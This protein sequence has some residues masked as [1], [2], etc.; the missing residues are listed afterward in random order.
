MALL[1]SWVTACGNAANE[2]SGSG[3]TGGSLG[4]AGTGGTSGQGGSVSGASGSTAAGGGA[5]AAAGAA[6]LAG[7]AGSSGAAGTSGC[8]QSPCPPEPC[9]LDGSCTCRNDADC[10]DANACNGLE[11]C[12]ADTGFCA[13]G[14]GV[15]CEASDDLCLTVACNPETGACDVS[16]AA[17]DTPCSDGNACTTND[18]C[19]EGVCEGRG[20]VV[21]SAVDACHLPGT[22]DPETGSCTNPEQPDGTTC[23]DGDACTNGDACDDGVC[24][25]SEPVV[26]TP[27]SA[28]HLA[29][30]CDP[31]SGECSNPLAP[32]GTECDDGLVC[33]TSDT[34]TAGNCGGAAMVCNDGIACTVDACL[35]TAGGC[36]ANGSACA[37]A[38]DA[39]CDDGNA[40]NGTER[41][42]LTTLQCL[43]GTAKDCRSFDTACG[44]GSCNPSTGECFSQPKRN[45]TTCSDDNAC[46]RS[47]SCQNGTC[48][49][50][51]PVVCTASDQCHAAG[52]CNP[53]TGTCSN[54]AK[55]NGA[56]CNDGNACTRSDSCQDGA[57]AGANPIVCA[58][59]DQCHNAGTC[60]PSSGVCSNPAKSNGS[61]C[62]DGNACT[63]SDSCQS[64]TCTG[65]NPVLCTASDQCHN[66]GTCDTTSGTCSN[67]AKSDG[68]TCNDGDACTPTD[69]CAS[70]VCTGTGSTCGTCDDE[71]PLYTGRV[72]RYVLE[73]QVACHFPVNT[74]PMY[75]A[76]M[77]EADYA[78]A[79]ACGACVE[80]T[81]PETAQTITLLVADKCPYAG[82]EEWCYPGSHH[83]D[84]N[85][86][87]YAA[88]GANNNPAVIWRYIPCP[89]PGNLRYYIDPG[90]NAFWLGVTPMYH[91]YRLAKLE[92]MKNGSFQ[93]LN[94]ASYNVWIM[95]GGAGNGPF[96]FRAT[97]IYGHV[98]ETSNVPFT[99]GGVLD[100]RAQFPACQ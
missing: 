95:N 59:S 66:A 58:A 85:P 83:L 73:S 7:S 30:S 76:A 42:D 47:D 90:S 94:R 40:C 46:T 52:T 32:N 61:A 84:L 75:Y 4:R 70:G 18:R 62:N 50:R 63:R 1:A 43:T 22:C 38:E 78:A 36:S 88:L 12:D 6:G 72:T 34:C 65:A 69:R 21:C 48:T 15:T 89:D 45:G 14:T 98:I 71:A 49:G 64:G 5:G 86:A 25:G 93:A 56:T 96:T 53:Q 68:T 20:V 92:V 99:L 13:P 100:G 60:A 80:V 19:L 74:L 33:T 79:G 39:D 37:C 57:C 28:C 23:D 41:C 10:D 44:T 51:N 55:A 17:D 87:A 35:E 91:R 97:D 54:P 82:N 24:A 27:L 29:G 77:N 11:T 9:E 8:A 2:D 81:N 67:P 16:P 31:E 3:A 26:C